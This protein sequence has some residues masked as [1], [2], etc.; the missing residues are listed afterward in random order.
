MQASVLFK[1]ILFVAL[2]ILD[3]HYDVQVLFESI[4]VRLITEQLASHRIYVPINN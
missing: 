1:H 2:N 4:N 3:A